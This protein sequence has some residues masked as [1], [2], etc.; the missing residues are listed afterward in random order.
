MLER[1]KKST[2]WSV[3]HRVQE[4]QGNYRAGAL[5]LVSI[6]SLFPLLILTSSVAGYLTVDRVDTARS[7]V[8]FFGFSESSEEF[9]E[10]FLQS[11]QDNRLGGGLVGLGGALLALYSFYNIINY[12]INSCWQVEVK[13]RL[14]KGLAWLLGSLF[15]L[16]LTSFISSSLHLFS[17]HWLVGL[18]VLLLALGL[19][20]ILLL[21]TYKLLSSRNLSL[22]SHFYGALFVG[23][24]MEVI[25][26]LSLVFP[27]LIAGSSLLYGAFG[28]VAGILA[29]LYLLSR[30]FVYGTVL[31]VVLY[32]KRFGTQTVQVEIPRVQG[33]VALKA[34]RSGSV[35]NVKSRKK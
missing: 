4:L 2:T 12:L 7:I 11:A 26:Q 22:S 18:G 34:T 30:V 20:T 21:W 23:V 5:T 10:S 6:F 8:E 14:I 35:K 24:S 28:A 17:N 3:Y 27:Q 15:L 32:E 33:E 9:F 29:S 31:N 16:T 25:K 19:N 1:V 13:F